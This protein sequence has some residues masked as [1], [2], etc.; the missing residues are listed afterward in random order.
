VFNGS[1]VAGQAGQTGEG[2]E[3]AGFDVVE[4]G[5]ATA[6][7]ESIVRYPSVLAP[8]AAELISLLAFDPDIE[9]DESVESVVLIT[10]ADFRGLAAEQR[11][12]TPLGTTPPTTTPPATA[13]PTSAAPGIVP[14]A[15]P[16]G[17]ACS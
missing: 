7:S 1:G 13:P 16:E 3:A 8:A 10:G 6:R 9:I 12:L 15:S 17:T 2:L 11:P 5:D 4:I 14:E